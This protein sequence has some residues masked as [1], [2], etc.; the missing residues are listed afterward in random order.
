MRIV[1]PYC[2]E[3][4]HQE[5]TY[6]GDATATRPDITSSSVEDHAAFVFDRANPAGAHKELWI[7]TGGCRQH[8]EV[9]RD[10]LTHAITKC[11]GVGPWWKKMRKKAVKKTPNKT[12]RSDRKVSK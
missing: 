10:T 9:T 5:F 3:R 4:D 12:T 11:E 7:H 2:G 8:V 1:C 6:K